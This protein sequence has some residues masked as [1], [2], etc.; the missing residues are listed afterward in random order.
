MHI[1]EQVILCFVSLN[2]IYVLEEVLIN[3]QMD[4]VV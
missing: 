1:L 3:A 4:L 2:V